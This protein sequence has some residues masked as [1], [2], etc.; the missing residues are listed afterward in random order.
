M[1]LM[2]RAQLEKLSQSELIDK[3]IETERELGRHKVVSLLDTME[4]NEAVEKMKGLIGQMEH[5]DKMALL[6]E[7]SGN[8]AHEIN[9]PLLVLTGY[10]GKLSRYVEQN[11][12]ELEKV[13]KATE[14]INA[15]TKRIQFIVKGMLKFSR[16]DSVLDYVEEKVQTLV[17]DTIVLIESKMKTNGVDFTVEEFEKE[18]KIDCSPVQLTQVFL[19]LLGNACDAVSNHDEPWVRFTVS[20]MGEWIEFRVVDSGKGIAKS[21]QDS[22][23]KR[24]FTTKKIG[25]GTG[26][27]L[28]ISSEI[29]RAHGGELFVD[30]S[31]A[32]TT[33]VVKV[34]KNKISR[35]ASSNAS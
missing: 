8:M 14:R 25:K 10:I 12:L 17:E 2:T 15:M 29:V 30:D 5:A 27:G 1:A 9:N 7:I 28:S 21:T 3:V 11:D 6:G 23:F 26:L 24:G 13:A 33:F 16:G 34:P 18:L 20:S 4:K 19:N 35:Q 31:C 22:L 32:N